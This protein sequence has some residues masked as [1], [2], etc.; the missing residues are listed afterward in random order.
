MTQLDA[1]G[2][3]VFLMV[4]TVECILHIEDIAA[5]SG[6]DVL[7]IG[8]ND[9]S[10]ELGIQGQWDHPTLRQ[11]LETVAN[12]CKKNGV[13]LGLAGLYNRLEICKDAINRLGAKY[14]L[15]NLDLGLLSEAAKSN[16]TT[17][18][19]LEV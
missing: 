2:S 18:K 19:E 15:G 14:I 10:L 3:T 9:L 17:L 16:V 11:T 8:A 1:S 6:V 5:V 12:A 4:E 13:I 7:L